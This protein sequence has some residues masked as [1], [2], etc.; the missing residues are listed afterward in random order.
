MR[1]SGLVVVTIGA[2]ALAACHDGGAILSDARPD[3]NT[4]I[5]AN[6]T[7]DADTVAPDTLLDS[8][9]KAATNQTAASFAFHADK[10]NSTFAC[11]LD[12][13]TA[14]A[15]S[16]PQSYTV[17]EGAHT[18][19]V[20]A[21]DGGGL[22]DPTPATFAWTVDT[23]PPDT[24]LT[25][26]PPALDNSVNVEF[27]FTS[28]DGATFECSLD[29]AAYASCV[30]PDLIGGLT[31]GVHSFDV[32]AID[33]VG[34][35]DP[36]PAH[37]AWTIDTSTPDTVIDAGPTGFV[38]L[39]TA[40]F[41]FSSPNA[42]AGATFRCALDGAAPAPCTSP[43]T[44]NGLGETPAP[45][46]FTVAVTNAAGTSDPTPATRSWTVD[47]TSPLVTITSGPSGPTNV[48][49]PVF[50]FT[51]DGSPASVQCQIDGAPLADCTSPYTSAAL[52]DGAH[53]F[54][55]VATDAAGNV[56]TASRAFVVDT[57]PP[58]VTITSGPSGP[59]NDATPTFTFTTAGNPVDVE[60]GIDNA[61]FAPCASPYTAAALADGAHELDVRAVDAAGNAGAASRA[62]TVDTQP[63]TVAI[64]G[65]PNGLTNV[66]TPTFTFTTGGSPTST[67]C[68]IDSGA[69]VACSASFTPAAALADG[70]HTFTVQVADAAGNS[71]SASRSF[72]VDATPPTVAITGGP[73]GLT[74]D[75]TPTFTFT[76]GGSP[77]S[78]QC[79]LDGGAAA[80]CTSPFTTASLADGAHTFTVTATDAAGNTASASRSFTVDATPPT[81]AITSGPNGLTNIATPTFTFTTGG[82]P[83]TV[84]CQ[85]DGGAA[86]ACAS[87]FTAATLADGTHTFTVQ[88]IDAAGNSASASR[89]FTVD[90]TPP[91]VAITGGP[92]GLTNDPTPT[93]TFTTGGSP[94]SVQCALDGGAAAACTSP[95]TTA[96]LP[97][98]AHTFT[99]TATDAAGNTASA[100]RSFTV[101]A[102]PPTVT[103]TGGP[104]GLTNIAAPIF[105]FA[106]GGNPTTVQCQ[107]DSGALAA[108]TSPYASASLADGAHTFTLAA[109]DAAGNTASASRAFTIDATPPTVTITGGPTGLTNNATP[110]FTFTTG[111]SPTTTQC[112]IGSGAFTACTTSFTPAA[113]LADGTYVFEVQV[114]DAA[115]NT[116]NATRGF[117]VDATPPTVAITSGPNG[118]TNNNQPT[119][120][121]TTGGSPTTTQC[122]IGTGAYTACALVFTPSAPLAD[123][124][125]TFEVQVIDAAGNSA[126]ATRTFT[127]DATPPTVT[128]TGGPSGTIAISQPTFTFT[129]GGNPTT[130]QC[131]FNTGAFV[132]CTSPFTPASITCTSN[133]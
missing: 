14:T 133:V 23:T 91:T 88:A 22:S 101:D 57:Q 118:L 7:P 100:S 106:I 93:F 99:V 84:Q 129:T 24:T 5:D 119:F 26:T 39:A 21:T 6:T 98:G 67:Q 2:L 63:P 37:Y 8:S 15:C 72:T 96:S 55:V 124:S 102:T 36:T 125:Y 48:V 89:S 19:T 31:D 20:T 51:A 34:N 86:A 58:T 78:V 128:I 80:A 45:H 47:L 32:R 114:V 126:S 110:T 111:G 77:T 127:V 115:G 70:A 28:E 94:T 109:S 130:T 40:T 97:D 43:I 85:L 75:P 41:A 68:K 60:C 35:V 74:N 38:N 131:R 10:P 66:A 83:T 69:L 29:G 44:Y 50:A 104:N 105:T 9:P 82:N 54:R 56:G 71:A 16:S 62:F 123:G 103:I 107:M 120:S 117:T 79:A 18:F 92:T 112:R 12:G 3:T 87:P 73:T 122:R 11:A 64:T 49:A 90:A 42:G 27:D 61:G 59:T 81:V 30:S 13:G 4:T 33:A 116:A 76:T 25:K 108:C 52:A 65:G 46:V 113:A 17:A 95:F 132:A 1:F 53:T 121:F